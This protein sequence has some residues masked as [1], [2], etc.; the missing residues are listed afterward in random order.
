MTVSTTTNS[1]SY[2]GSGTTPFSFPYK[3]FANTDLVVKRR[4]S[5]G[6]L[7]TLVLNTDYTVSGAGSDSGGT[8]TPLA[9]ET[10]NTITIIR[11]VS[12]T[13]GVDLQDLG[14]FP[15]E[16]VEG[17]L[18]RLTMLIQEALDAVSRAIVA[19]QGDT[20]VGLELAGATSRA[21]RL[22]G[23]GGSGEVTT[24]PASVSYVNEGSWETIASASTVDITGATSRNKNITGTTTITSFGT[25][26]DGMTR[27]LR[28]AGVLTITQNSNIECLNGTNMATEAGDMAAITWQNGKWR[29]MDY[30][31]YTGQPFTAATTTIFTGMMVMWPLT[32]SAPTGWLVCDGAA[33]SR[34][35]YSALFA[36]I[37]TTYGTGDGST[38]F[39]LPNPDDMILMG[40]G[41][42]T[43]L[44]RTSGSFSAT[45]GAAG[46]HDHGA[47][48]GGTA[49][50]LSQ[51]PAHS[52]NLPLTNTNPGATTALGD[53]T[54]YTSITTSDNLATASQGSGATHNH[55]IA[56]VSDHTHSLTLSPPKFGARVIIKT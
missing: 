12:R 49:L 54:K 35:T 19:P 50:T 31:R 26:S 6:V 37:G 2:T 46:G 28:F 3:F 8:V 1:Q 14:A 5:A 16:G 42:G 27:F 4:T 52:H 15:A 18:D 10:G 51:I 45:T 39:N 13:Q 47:A 38:T 29:F 53:A 17:A 24:Y 9:S 40:Y 55:T 48:T 41:A 34:T 11:Q 20:V 43:P 32:G 56:S 44:G 33:V 22:L 25:G 23:F 21:S 36:L 30:Q 7:N